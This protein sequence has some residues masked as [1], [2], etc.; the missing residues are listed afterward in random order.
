MGRG[1]P[2]P[3]ISKQSLARLKNGARRNTTQ[4]ASPRLQ[5]LTLVVRTGTPVPQRSK[6]EQ[7][8]LIHRVLKGDAPQEG[9]P[10][11]GY[12]PCLSAFTRTG[13]I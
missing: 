1:Q 7:E 9:D 12:G 10:Q 3:W 8:L 4:A 13:A 6:E 5:F 2:A 11:D